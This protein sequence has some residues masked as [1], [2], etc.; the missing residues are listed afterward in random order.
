MLTNFVNSN[1]KNMMFQK[2]KEQGTSQ[3]QKC[4]TQEITVR[5]PTKRTG[6]YDTFGNSNF[7]GFFKP[8][9]LGSFLFENFIFF[10]N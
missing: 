1:K 5:M 2:S 9:C 10:H 3:C 6:S 7:E 4:S 8:V